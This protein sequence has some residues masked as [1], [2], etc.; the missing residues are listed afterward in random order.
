MAVVGLEKTFYAVAEEEKM[1]EV[2]VVVK[3]PD[4]EEEGC[5]VVSSFDIV[6]STVDDTAGK[7]ISSPSIER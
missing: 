2:C 3:N 7:Y 4:Y 6:I 1:I 5:P